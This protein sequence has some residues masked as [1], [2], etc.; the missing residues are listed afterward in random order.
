M[1]APAAEGS[2]NRSAMRRIR[3][4]ET[5]YLGA[6]RAVLAAAVLIGLLAVAAAAAIQLYGHLT[7]AGTRT[8]DDYFRAPTW[9]SVRP[10]VLPPP[11]AE[12]TAAKRAK[13]AAASGAP[14]GPDPR[15][16]QIA[17]HL[18]AQFSRNAGNEA[19]FTDRFPK[20]LLESWIMEESVPPAHLADYVNELTVVS[21]AIGD[22][23]R[24][25]RIGSLDDRAEVIMEALR[26]FNRAFLARISEAERQAAAAR[27]AD[28]GRRA[29][30]GSAALFLGL[31][32]LGLLV[33]VLLIVI[34]IRIEAHLHEQVRLQRQRH[35]GVQRGL[36][37]LCIVGGALVALS[38]APP[39]EAAAGPSGA[40][41]F[42]G[43]D[44]TIVSDR[45]NRAGQSRDEV[46]NELAE[47]L[48]VKLRQFDEC[49]ERLGSGQAEA[50]SAEASAAAAGGGS[51][52]QGAS[53]SNGGG[54]GGAGGEMERVAQSEPSGSKAGGAD[55]AGSMANGRRTGEAVEPPAGRRS[56]ASRAEDAGRSGGMP[57]TRP[58][59]DDIARILREAAEKETDPSR[60]AALWEEYENYVRNL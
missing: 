5:G 35:E 22:D 40:D 33:S 7:T 15:I 10:E 51:G 45:G 59:E 31:G 32:G 34:L 24:I 29:E 18:N 3:R 17:D 56:T 58:P 16:L 53:G 41:G 27:A 9:E 6:V 39:G 57:R 60:Q 25:N 44:W 48:A 49:A 8:A 43:C 46:A 23:G 54:E 21:K 13:A 26:V 30:T 50:S 2:N 55:A 28:D 36:S 14:R 52:G 19:Y 4:I 12:P 38:G 11:T 20:R 37:A 1:E 47:E 42:S